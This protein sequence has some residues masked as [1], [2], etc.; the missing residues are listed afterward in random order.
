MKAGLIF[1][2]LLFCQNSFADGFIVVNCWKGLSDH[3]QK[4]N[5]AYCLSGRQERQKCSANIWEHQQAVWDVCLMEAVGPLN[6][7]KVFKG[8]NQKEQNANLAQCRKEE[9]QNSVCVSNAWTHG[10]AV[11]DVCLMTPAVP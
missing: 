9:S 4:R 8:F 11:Y 2:G 10:Q 1:L 5:M 7:I 6:L 3:D